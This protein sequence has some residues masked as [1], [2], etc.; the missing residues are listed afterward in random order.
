MTFVLLTIG[1][2]SVSFGS[3]VRMQSTNRWMRFFVLVV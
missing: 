2:A 3:G 1:V